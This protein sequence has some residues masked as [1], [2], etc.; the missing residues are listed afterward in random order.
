[1]IPPLYCCHTKSVRSDSY[2]RRLRKD[3]PAPRELWETPRYQLRF[4]SVPRNIDE[5]GKESTTARAL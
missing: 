2:N 3:I 5:A 4:T 1:M